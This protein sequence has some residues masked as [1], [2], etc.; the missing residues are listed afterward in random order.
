MTGLGVICTYIAL[1]LRKENIWD[2]IALGFGLG[3]G[4]LTKQTFLLYA[5]IPLGILFLIFI[6]QVL[7]ISF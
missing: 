3:L 7:H 5:V 6:L 1:S 4:L 2:Y